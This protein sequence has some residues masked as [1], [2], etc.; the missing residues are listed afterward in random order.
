MR[1]W[2]EDLIGHLPRPQLLGQH[3]ECCALRGNGWGKKHATVDYVFSYSPYVLYQYHTLIMDEMERRGYNVTPEWKR[4]RIVEKF[5][6]RIP[7]WRNVRGRVRYTKS[8]MM[9]I[10]KN[11]LKI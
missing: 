8:T 4:L 2:H 1:L 9:R 3:R 7:K 6:R 10:T 5:A 11:V